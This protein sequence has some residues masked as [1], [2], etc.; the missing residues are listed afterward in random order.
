[1]FKVTV[2]AICKNEI[3]NLMDWYESVREADCVCVLD[4][5]STDGTWELLQNLP[6]IAQQKII[7]PWSFGE[8]RSEAWK[9]IP[10]DTDWVVIVDLDERLN[11][12]WRGFLKEEI[13]TPFNIGL[14]PRKEISPGNVPEI[15]N[16]IPR[17]IYFNKDITWKFSVS[18]E[19]FLGH[20]PLFS[21]GVYSIR[22][23]EKIE[24]CHFFEKTKNF[25]FSEKR[26]NLQKMRLQESID[27]ISKENISPIDKILIA[28][29]GMSLFESIRNSE[30]LIDDFKPLIS[31]LEEQEEDYYLSEANYSFAKNLICLGK[32][33]L[34]EDP[35]EVYN[36]CMSTPS[37]NV[38]FSSEFLKYFISTLDR[39]CSLSFFRKVLVDF[40]KGGINLPSEAENFKEMVFL[41]EH[42]FRAEDRSNL[43]DFLEKLNAVPFKPFKYTV[44]IWI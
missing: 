4:T 34:K 14:I 25:P 31:F 33:L 29:Q 21:Y 2:C 32:V 17:I 42:W 1:M 3:N 43:K 20:T 26:K 18:E 23:I 35:K 22:K 15:I 10:L 38:Y 40:E 5:G 6:L 28:E 44:Y 41:I 12:G 8:A 13:S 36:M 19:P 27:L 16:F 37:T 39:S 9:L 7:E 11:K 30:I 24:M